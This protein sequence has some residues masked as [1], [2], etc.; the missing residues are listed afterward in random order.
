MKVL[1]RIKKMLNICLSTKLSD[2][3]IIE[4]YRKNEVVQECIKQRVDLYNKF[5]EDETNRIKM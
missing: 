5:I 2:K 3:D 4:Q 1:K